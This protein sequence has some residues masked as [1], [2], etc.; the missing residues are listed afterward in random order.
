MGCIYFPQGKTGIAWAKCL[1][2][3]DPFVAVKLEQFFSI[4]EEICAFHPFTILA[5]VMV[6]LQYGR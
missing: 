1:L 6:N 4:W 3:E 5:N 2:D